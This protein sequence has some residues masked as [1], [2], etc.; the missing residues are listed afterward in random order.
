MAQGEK[1]TCDT[2]LLNS[3]KHLLQA[4]HLQRMMD[5]NPVRNG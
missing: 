2:P 3:K 1:C 4:V 5:R